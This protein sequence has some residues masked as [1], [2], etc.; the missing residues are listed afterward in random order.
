M[1]S[2]L[3]PY[4]DHANQVASEL[5]Q[6]SSQLKCRQLNFNVRVSAHTGTR[7]S[8]LAELGAAIK[9]ELDKLRDPQ[10]FWKHELER[11]ATSHVIAAV[12]IYDKEAARGHSPDGEVE[13]SLK[14]LF[15]Q[16]R[17]SP[18]RP[19]P[20]DPFRPADQN[21][22]QMV[23]GPAGS[24]QKIARVFSRGFNYTDRN[25]RERLIRKAGVEIYR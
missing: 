22:I 25:G 14:A 5:K 15:E 1:E 12:D 10:T 16:T 6:F 2:K 24:S 18:L 13:K 11:L 3:R 20:G 7:D 9:R 19:Q 8:F 23:A 17:L 4:I 21:L